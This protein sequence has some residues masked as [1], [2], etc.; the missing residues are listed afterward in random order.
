MI[1]NGEWERKTLEAIA[2]EAG[3]NNRNTFTTAFKKETGLS[4]F[5]YLKEV[6]GYHDV[7]RSLLGVVNKRMVV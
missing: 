1:I 2:S 4:P 6:K 5:E 7:N 3:F